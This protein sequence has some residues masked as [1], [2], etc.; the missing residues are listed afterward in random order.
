VRQVIALL[1]AVLVCG[2]AAWAQ[3]KPIVPLSAVSPQ[4][5]LTG[6][7]KVL[8]VCRQL[9]LSE[10]QRKQAR[11]LIESFL[12]NDAGADDIP[13]T[14]I[15]QIVKEIEEAQKAGD[16]A[17]EQKLTD[18]L[19]SYGENR[20][21]SSD[22]VFVNLE[23][24]LTDSQKA[25]FKDV[26]ARLERNPSGAIRP[27]DV[28]R[29]LDSLKL[30]PEQEQ[31]IPVLRKQ[32]YRATRSMQTVKDNDRFQIMNG[33][34]VEIG[35][36]LTPEQQEPYQRLLSRLRPDLAYRMRVMASAEEEAFLQQAKE[37]GETP[38]K[39]ED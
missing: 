24:I 16:K 27:I 20:P 31:R 30:T 35:N 2:D 13:L 18:E 10:A 29:E 28:F 34:L 15:Y 21:D 23:T 7:K 3:Q 14:R 17:T 8:Y 32:V 25:K 9:D 37:R 11:G 4:G 1:A 19:R 33:L 36:M 6:R 39:S 5:K 22:E 26:R 12:D 38:E